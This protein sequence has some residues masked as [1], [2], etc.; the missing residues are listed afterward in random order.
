MFSLEASKW[1]RQTTIVKTMSIMSCYCEGSVFLR[2]PLLHE[3]FSKEIHTLHY[4]ME[5]FVHFKMHNQVMILVLEFGKK[6]L[7]ID[8]SEGH[9]I[10]LSH[11]LTLKISN[12]LTPKDSSS[13]H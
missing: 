6:K 1:K 8:Y 13:K 5:W 9:D 4:K 2:Y 12:S 7:A 3:N 11:K 10:T